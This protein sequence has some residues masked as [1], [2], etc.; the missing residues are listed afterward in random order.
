MARKKLGTWPRP[1]SGQPDSDGGS[2]S[3]AGVSRPAN[4]TAAARKFIS[5][6]PEAVTYSDI[7]AGVQSQHGF[8]IKN[9]DVSNAKA[10]LRKAGDNTG[11][12]KVKGRKKI[13]TLAERRAAKAAANNT[14]VTHT[15]NTAAAPKPAATT[16]SGDVVSAT[17]DLV[18]AVG[19]AQARAIIAGLGK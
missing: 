1:I 3:A 16:S 18:A 9:G 13:G 7:I 19:L 14:A 12:R 11:I 4:K 2:A 8:E 10:F 5:E 6:H 17:L 15:A